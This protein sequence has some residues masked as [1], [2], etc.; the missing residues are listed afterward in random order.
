MKIAW[1]HLAEGFYQLYKQAVDAQIAK[2]WQA[3]WVLRGGERWKRVKEMGGSRKPTEQVLRAWK[4]A[5]A[6]GVVWDHAAFPKAKA[7]REGGHPTLLSPAERVFGEVRRWVEGRRYE[8]I[9]AKKAAV[10]GCYD[11]WK[12]RGRSHRW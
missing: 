7:V 8:R 1:K 3:L 10:E 5:G 2:R 4:G 11:G 9:E 6:Q 12:P